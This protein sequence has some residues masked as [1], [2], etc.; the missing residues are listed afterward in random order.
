VPDVLAEGRVRLSPAAASPAGALPPGRTRGGATGDR[1]PAPAGLRRDGAAAPCR[2]VRLTPSRW[3]AWWIER[4]VQ[5]QRTAQ[6]RA[7]WVA[8]PARAA[9]GWKAAGRAGAAALAA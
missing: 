4:D 9:R 8:A 7:A 6:Q 2:G 1:Q 3:R 5:R